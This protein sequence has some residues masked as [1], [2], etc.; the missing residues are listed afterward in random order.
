M[1]SGLGASGEVGYVWSKARIVELLHCGLA[2][3]YPKQYQTCAG[4]CHRAS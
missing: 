2:F 4:E 3:L 1:S